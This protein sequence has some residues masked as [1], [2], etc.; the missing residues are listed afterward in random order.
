ML[1]LLSKLRPALSGDG[2][3]AQIAA[4]NAQREAARAKV[5]EAH[6]A[7]EA[8]VQRAVAGQASWDDVATAKAALL[9]ARA[10]R[11]LLTKAADLAES[12][13]TQAQKAAAVDA[14]WA[15]TIK[16]CRE[17]EVIAVRLQSRLEKAAKDYALLVAANA[18]VHHSLPPGFPARDTEDFSVAGDLAPNLVRVEYSRHGLPGGPLLM[19]VEPQLLA[20]RYKVATQCAERARAAAQE[21]DVG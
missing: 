1:N 4:L 5:N 15:A 18:T 16:A 13:Q 12:H 6:D 9:D 20:E 7:F 11:R 3:P 21:V 10:N 2:A 8:A 17:R 19:G 14:A